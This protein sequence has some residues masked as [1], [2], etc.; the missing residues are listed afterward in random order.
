MEP[1]GFVVGGTITTPQGDATIIDIRGKAWL[2]VETNETVKRGW[3]KT[4]DLAEL[5]P[6]AHAEFVGTFEA[7][8]AARAAAAEAKK[9]AREE[10]DETGEKPKRGRRKKTETVEV[11]IDNSAAEGEADEAAEAEAEFATV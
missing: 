3:W 9:A 4:D 7:K 10:G 5:N 1:S 2:K 6:D 11:E 8:K